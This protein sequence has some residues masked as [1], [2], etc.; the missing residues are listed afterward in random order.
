MDRFQCLQ[1]FVTVLEE[2][3]FSGAARRLKMSPPAVTRA[4]AY[5]EEHLG[6]KLL[7]RTTRHVRA[8]EAGTRYLSDARQILQSM[9][10]ADN[11][12]QGINAE[13]KGLLGV[14]AP[15]FFGRM[16][17]LPSI[18]DYLQRYPKTQVDAVFLDRRVNLLEE[19]LDVGVRIGE[20]PDSSM[21]ALRIGQVRSVIVAS[22]EYITAHGEPSRPDELNR[23]TLIASRAGDFSDSWHFRMDNREVLQRI[24]PAL[25]VTTIDAAIEAS[26]AGF[27]ITRLLSYQ[28]AE[29]VQAGQLK[30]LLEDFGPGTMPVH[31]IHR[32]GRYASAKVRSFIDLLAHK[33]SDEAALQGL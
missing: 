31:I 14:T 28:V 10:A 7:N 11:A 19:G 6:V 12:A 22:P 15:V 26:I 24:D 1:V 25:T 17:V 8:T 23:H 33:L 9:D 32:E 3:S 20:L 30:L 27:G 2:Q 4:V 5:L 21:R 29:A 13:P 18:T 16:Y